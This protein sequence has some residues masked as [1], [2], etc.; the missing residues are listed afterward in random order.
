MIYST[1]LIIESKRDY[2]AD[3]PMEMKILTWDRNNDFGGVEPNDSNHSHLHRFLQLKNT[4]IVRLTS[5]NLQK[6]NQNPVFKSTFIFLD[7]FT[8]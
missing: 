3:M 4:T 7:V 2:D 1:I 6:K 8:D 5:I